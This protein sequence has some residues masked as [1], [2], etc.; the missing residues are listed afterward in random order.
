MPKDSGRN[1]KP[2][3]ERPKSSP[4]TS[5]PE[6]HD[7]HGT[8]FKRVSGPGPND[9]GKGAAGAEAINRVEGGLERVPDQSAPEEDAKAEHESE[10]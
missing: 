6:G 8:T 2:S 5:G 4:T 3:R 10:D 7:S 1:T 9:A